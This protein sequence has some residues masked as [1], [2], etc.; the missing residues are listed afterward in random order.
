[1]AFNQNIGNIYVQKPKRG[2]PTLAEKAYRLEKESQQPYCICNKPSEGPMIGCDN[3][4][5]EITWNEFLLKMYQ[6]VNGTA[7]HVNNLILIIN[8]N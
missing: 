3:K 1:M 8:I 4:K 6:K 2:R 5:C 7:Q